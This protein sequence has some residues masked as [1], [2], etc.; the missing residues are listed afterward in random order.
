VTFSQQ[1]TRCK[2]DNRSPHL[3]STPPAP[4][5]DQFAAPQ[6]STRTV[7]LDCSF[8]GHHSP[9]PGHPHLPFESKQPIP[10]L[11][12]ISSLGLISNRCERFDERQPPLDSHIPR[13]RASPITTH[14]P[15]APPSLH[16]VLTHPGRD[17]HAQHS[18]SF[19]AARAKGAVRSPPVRQFASAKSPS[20]S[21]SHP[22]QSRSAIP[23][24]I[25]GRVIFSTAVS[26]NSSSPP[27]R[28]KYI[29]ENI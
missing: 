20:P 12:F 1:F 15:G 8:P 10:L 21:L 27:G 3:I 16:L 14:F 2:P 26:I 11:R 29:L 7:D 4:D 23:A 13:K 6:S 18:I 24:R 5:R 17:P 19:R 9:R 28:P 22:D 25:L